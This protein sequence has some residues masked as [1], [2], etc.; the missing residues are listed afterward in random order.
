MTNQEKLRQMLVMQ[1]EMNTIV[2]PDW[3]NAGYAWYRAVWV[4]L[5]EIMDPIFKWWKKVDPDWQQLELEAV[6][7]FHFGLSDMLLHSNIEEI[8][9][10][11]SEATEVPLGERASIGEIHAA[12]ESLLESTIV[13]KEFDMSN[14]MDLCDVMGITFDSLYKQYVGKNILNRFRQSRGYQDGTYIKNWNGLED[15]EVLSKI[16]DTLTPDIDDVPGYLMSALDSA[17]QEVCATV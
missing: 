6:D 17:Y 10:R 9:E 7:I 11:Y 16:L 14:F 12:V 3:K 4:E 1:D 5:A 8:S 13:R 15:N 2:N